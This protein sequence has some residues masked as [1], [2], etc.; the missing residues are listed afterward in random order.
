L[1]EPFS[2]LFEDDHCLALVKPAGQCTVGKWA[3][4]G[5]ATLETAVRQYLNPADP[6]AVYLGIVHRLDTPTSG[7]ILWAK[8]IKAARRLSTQFQ[9][10]RVVK[11][12]WA[13]VE[14]RGSTTNPH[15]TPPE[16]FGRDAVTGEQVWQDWLARVDGSGRA[17]VVDQG[18]RG[19][20]EALTK[21]CLARAV[22]LPSGCAWLRLWPETGRTHQL[23][24]QAARRG[25]PILGDATYGSTR[26]LQRPQGIALHAR[27]LQ[28][29][30]PTSG[31]QMTLVAP[32][33][34]W[35]GDEGIVLPD[36]VD[37][38]TS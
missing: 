10:R 2:I 35:W 31:R 36:V 38:V 18:Q 34:T 9:G 32:A 27:A 37:R 1:N 16:T 3:P 24:I 25:M 17:S 8:T 20:R 4:A 12:Y 26:P 28:L 30:H 15:D 6:G 14:L 33:P 13:V 11:E 29:N 5:E 7:V 23:R 21:L 19:S 22:R